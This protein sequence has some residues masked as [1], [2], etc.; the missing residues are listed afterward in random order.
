MNTIVEKTIVNFF[1]PL[2]NKKELSYDNYDI[3]KN[4]IRDETNTTEYLLRAL[5]HNYIGLTPFNIVKINN[6]ES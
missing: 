6:A 1:S 5:S 2:K 3:L 4:L